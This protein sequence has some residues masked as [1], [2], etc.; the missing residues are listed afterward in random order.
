MKLEKAVDSCLFR[1]FGYAFDIA[2]GVLG[3]GV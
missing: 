1:V 2:P 3:V